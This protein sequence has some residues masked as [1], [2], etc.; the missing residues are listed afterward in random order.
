M[1]KHDRRTP[2]RKN[3]INLGQTRAGQGLV[4]MLP[5]CRIK[6][7]SNCIEYCM[8]WWN[9]RCSVC[10]GWTTGKGTWRNTVNPG[11]INHTIIENKLN[12]TITVNQINDNY[13]CFLHLTFLVCIVKTCG[14]CVFWVACM[15]HL[16][17]NCW[18]HFEWLDIFLQ[19]PLSLAYKL[20]NIF[21]NVNTILWFLKF[22]NFEIE[23]CNYNKTELSSQRV[24][25]L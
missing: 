12:D 25:G 8:S 5:R 14:L 16:N 11:N 13:K 7:R 2:E 23:V 3:T 15:F 4:H 19:K 6:K 17:V 1:E 18:Q 10:C 9:M 22:S 24:Y 21:D 20:Q